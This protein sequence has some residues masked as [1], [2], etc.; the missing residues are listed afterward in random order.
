MNEL[1]ALAQRNSWSV[2]AVFCEKVS[3]AKK[4]AERK[5]L[6][7]MVEYVQAHHINKVAVTELSRLGRDTLQV[8][9]VIEKFNKLGRGT[10]NEKTHE[11][12]AE[13]YLQRIEELKQQIAIL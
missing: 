3:G 5:E 11:R 7:R 9:E 6:S 2:E 13:R 4:Y 12:I 10:I 8:F 1:T